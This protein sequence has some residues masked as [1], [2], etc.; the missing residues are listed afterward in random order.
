MQFRSIRV[1]GGIRSFYDLPLWA[2]A[3]LAPA[4]C[5]AACIVIVASVWLGTTETESRLAGVANVALP[6]AASSA[7]LLDQVDRVHVMAMRA[8]VWQQAGVQAATIDALTNDI[9]LGLETLRASTAATMSGRSDADADLALVGQIAA[10]STAYAKLL[11]D[12]LDL[13]ADPPIAVGYFRRADTAFEKLR[14]DIAALSDAGRAAEAGAI[15]AARASSHAALIRSYWIFSLSGMVMLVLLPVVVTAISRPV[16]A[17]TRTMTELVAGNMAAEAAGQD[18]RDELGDM[19]RAVRVFKDHMVRGNQLTAEKAAV[20]RHA[21]AEKRAALVDMAEKIEAETGT[22]LQRIGLRTAA[23]ATTADAMNASAART[24]T[25]A[26][27]ATA[28]ADLALTNAQTVAGAAEQLTASIRKISRQVTQST[29]VAGRAVAIGGEARSTIEA[30][31]HDVE[32]ISAVAG[33]IGEIAARTNLL[34]LNA[35]I[36]A[37]RA[38]DAGRGF[39][40]VASEVK[41]LATQT[42]RST[43]EIAQHIGQVRA[44]TDASVAAVLRIEQTINEI[45]AIAGSIAAAVA[46]QGAATEEIAHNVTET[47]NAANAMTSRTN[48]VSAAASETGRHAADV[49]DAATGLHASMEELRHSVIRVVRTATSDVDRRLNERFSVNLACRVTVDGRTHHA[50]VVDWSD[51]G[52]Q[53]HGALPMRANVHGMLDVD[54][55]GFALPFIVKT[56][57]SEAHHLAFALDAATAIRFGGLPARIGGRTAA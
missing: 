15:Q 44:A 16:R 37:A 6:A 32:R 42:A 49:R 51:T 56:G 50:W 21:E 8:L 29:A 38:G 41:A 11:G 57:D 20:G 17:L 12:A 24:G 9:G 39:A 13:V 5:L 40:V 48:D 53:V 54:G 25:S 1:I 18:H 34:A 23:M 33:I 30:L 43:R 35:T 47:A 31:N 2:K 45:D 7:V 19:A 36:E 22:A 3:L 27:D 14:A 4:A 28:A 52:A 55:V 10:Q 26:R 46:Q